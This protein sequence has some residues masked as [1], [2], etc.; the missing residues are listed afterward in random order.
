MALQ[1]Q[2]TTPGASS[3]WFSSVLEGFG[4]RTTSDDPR[5]GNTP[6]CT[7]NLYHYTSAKL[8]WPRFRLLRLLPSVFGQPI[9]CELYEASQGESY[10]ALSYVWGSDARVEPIKLN[11]ATLWNT[12]NLFAALQHC[13]PPQKLKIYSLG[14]LEVAG[15]ATRS[16]CAAETRGQSLGFF[17][18]SA[19]SP[20]TFRTEG[21]QHIGANGHAYCTSL[22]VLDSGAKEKSTPG[23]QS[24]VP[25]RVAQ[26]DSLASNRVST[27]FKRNK[28]AR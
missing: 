12:D 14:L 7:T 20:A 18:Q 11:D 23:V 5:V 13:S 26:L 17:G 3:W 2:T 1:S 15:R 25:S 27:W 21:A 6:D 16:V 24:R 4:T 9:Q 28:Q 22:P 10:E 19:L 8:C